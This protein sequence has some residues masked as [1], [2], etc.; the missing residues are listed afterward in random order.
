MNEYEF[1]MVVTKLQVGLLKLK[2]HYIYF[3]TYTYTY[4]KQRNI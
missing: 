2:T 3:Y 1:D 4:T